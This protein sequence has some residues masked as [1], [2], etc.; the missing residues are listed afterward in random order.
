MARRTKGR[1]SLLLITVLLAISASCTTRFVYSSVNRKAECIERGGFW[2]KNQCWKDF[3]YTGISALEIDSYVDSEMQKINDAI[4]VI[5]GKEYPFIG[6]ALPVSGKIAAIA[7]YYMEEQPMS[8]LVPMN[9]RNLKDGATFPS[10]V[11]L[12]KGDFFSDTE[13]KLAIGSVQVQVLSVDE[14]TLTFDGEIPA[15]NGSS[16]ILFNLKINAAVSGAGSSQLRVEDNV[17]YL[18]GTLGLRTYRQ[19]QDLVE[20]HPS[21]KT[22]VLT[23]V[24]GSLNDQVNMHTGRLVREH[25]FTTKVLSDSDIASGGVDLFCAGVERIVEQGAKIGVHSWCCMGDVTAAEIPKEHPA[26][27]DQLEYFEMALGEEI[28]ADFY[29]YTLSSAPFDGTYYM[30]DKEIQEWTVATQFITR[31]Q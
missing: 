17:A 23:Q 27:K 3:E 21:V 7:V 18:S 15:Q 11:M 6:G 22:I 8:L 14:I 1:T 2:Y 5:N 29:Y 20:N 28:G 13:E 9:S 10:E 16:D 31:Q 30:T 4:L 19:V 26:H 12:F 25:G 24:P